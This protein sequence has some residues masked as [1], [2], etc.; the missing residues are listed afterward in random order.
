VHMKIYTKNGDKGETALIGGRRVA[1]DDARIEAAGQVD[2]LSS[3]LGIVAAFSE[4]GEL[5][6]TITK[7]QRTLFVVGAD[8]ATPAGEKIAIP[9]LSPSKVGELE[10]LI[11]KVDADLP[12]IESFILPGGSK[13]AS[14]MHLA[15]TICRK[16]ERCV[17]TLDRYEKVNEAIPIYLNRLSDL[18]FVLARSINYRKKI[19]ETLWR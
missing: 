7:I 13:T 9:R 8:L 1:K 6:E 11:D 15:R 4:D 16:A 19:P 17:V 3:V 12:K 18:L 10:E 5:R 2:E 14:L